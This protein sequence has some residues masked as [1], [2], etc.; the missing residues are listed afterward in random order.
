MVSEAGKH[1][2]HVI[3][4]L[5][6]N[7]G[8]YG[9]R[10]QYVEWGREKGQKLGN[11]DEFYSNPLVKQFYKN[12]IK[13]VL[14]RTNTISKVVYKDDPTIFAWELM[15]EPRCES[16]PSGTTLQVFHFSGF[17]FKQTYKFR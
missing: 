10:K 13:A 7:F 12:H 5:V 3:I 8:D 17:F 6:N 1:G 14:T 2:I 11:E 15:N 9:G 16:D 4:S